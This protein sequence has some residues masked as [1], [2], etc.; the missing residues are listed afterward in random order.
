MNEKV[1]IK[2]ENMTRLS[3]YREQL[4]KNPRLTYL[5]IEMTNNCNLNCLHCG[6]GCSQN[7]YEYI[8]TDILLKTLKQLASD[9]NPKTIMICLTG[10]EPLLHP[11]FFKIV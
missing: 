2:S 6:S 9:Y 10:G 7:N 3:K 11:D 1:K 4:L 8:E 5:F